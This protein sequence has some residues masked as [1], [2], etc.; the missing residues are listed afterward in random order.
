ME[1]LRKRTFNDVLDKS[2]DRMEEMVRP[3]SV[4][5]EELEM[6]L[7]HICAK[8]EQALLL[9]RL[10]FYKKKKNALLTWLKGKGRYECA[11][12]SWRSGRG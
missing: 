1:R 5:R 8:L 10:F 6:G 4:E 3:S 2:G 11:L 12:E 7:R 9:R